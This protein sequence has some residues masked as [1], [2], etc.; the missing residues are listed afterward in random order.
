MQA[1]F[2]GPNG[3]GFRFGCGCGC[4]FNSF[5]VSG[6]RCLFVKLKYKSDIRNT[7]EKR[8]QRTPKRSKVQTKSCSVN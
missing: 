2:E 1:R 4:G 3:F 7:N 6:S 8:E 5:L